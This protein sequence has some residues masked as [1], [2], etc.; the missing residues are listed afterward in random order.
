MRHFNRQSRDYKFIEKVEAGLVLTGSDAKSLRVQPV[1]FQ[2]AQVEIQNGQPVIIGLNIPLYKYSQGQTIDTTRSRNLLLSS[3]Q[4]KKLQS[5]RK[6]K[7][8]L[9]PVTIYSQGVWFKLEIGIGRKLKKYEKREILKKR[10]FRK[11]F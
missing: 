8:M 10:E 3:S 9:I 6:Q 7:Y 11:S 2:S 5:Y 1:Q 4:I